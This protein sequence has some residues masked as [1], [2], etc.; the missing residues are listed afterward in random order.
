P[1]PAST[2]SH[3][4]VILGKKK[5]GRRVTLGI[6]NQ[7]LVIDE[8]DDTAPPRKFAIGDI[9]KCTVKK[10]VVTVN[11]AGATPAEFEFLCASAAE[12]ERV[13]DGIGAA[14]RG[15]FIGDR[16]LDARSD[17]PLQPPPLPPK[18]SVAPPP[19][20]PVT[21]TAALPA[22]PL[23]PAPA[24][25]EHAVVLYSFSG[26]DAE[27][28]TVDEG[29]RVLVLDKA[30]T[31]WWKVQLAPPH[32]RVGLVPA[33]YLELQAAGLG[34]GD[35]RRSVASES[36]PPLP[37][38]ADTIHDSDNV[39]L[40]TLQTL[41]RNQAAAAGPD[42]NMVRK[43][44]DGTGT[45]T[46]DAAFVRLDADG[47]VHLHKTN[48]KQISVAL[49]K[50][51]QEDQQY[52][53][54]LMGGTQQQQ[55]PAKPMTARQRQ[56]QQARSTPG[57]RTINYDWDWFDFFTLKCDVQADSA[58]KYATSFV[59]ERL[60]DESI[61]ELTAD[62]MASLGVKPDDIPRL[63]RGFRA[64]RGLQ[65]DAAEPQKEARS[66]STPSPLGTEPPLQAPRGGTAAPGASQPRSPV[67]PPSLAASP[68]PAP[69]RASNNPWGVDSELDRRVD[70]YNQIRT[71]ET[72]ARELQKREE[73]RRRPG[74]DRKQTI[75]QQ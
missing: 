20:P 35:S 29:A 12:T 57:R 69:R 44:T 9:A 10:T 74:Q 15:M 46:V 25:Q 55:Q 49:A 58:L 21:S 36:T 2:I 64:H 62:Y 16:V 33:S 5:K 31:E 27:E 7:C 53:A 38:R 75:K 32:G 30:D 34:D 45:Y 17:G 22:R 23:R 66:S 63:E 73:D 40:Q 65:A 47:T 4:N 72:F 13:A 68:E 43:W 51:S 11:I 18:D 28:L 70:R 50:F 54:G 41:Q 56:Q 14:R 37:T 52:V 3:F 26:D 48:N 6:S 39:P 24:S 61:P 59:A 67:S 42:A 8:H 19:P 1:K 60:D 71:D